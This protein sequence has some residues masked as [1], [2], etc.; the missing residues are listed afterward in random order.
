[1]KVNIWIIIQINLEIITSLHPEEYPDLS[2]LMQKTT[3]IS[4]LYAIMQHMQTYTTPVWPANNPRYF[5]FSIRNLV[6]W[7]KA[8]RYTGGVDTWQS[9]K[10]FL[11]H[12]G[13]IKTHPV[14]GEQE[15]QFL[16]SIWM[17][18]VKKGQ[19]SE[20]L[21]TV[22]FYT[23]AVLQQAEKIAREYREKHVNLTKITK[24]AIAIGWDQRT[25]DRLFRSSNHVVS[26]I[27]SQVKQCL[28]DAMDSMI[29]LHGYTT[30]AEMRSEALKQCQENLDINPTECLEL[31]DKLMA[32]KR[33]LIRDAGYA[34]H[35]IRKIDRQL[36][37]P[38][39]Y[40][41]YIITRLNIDEYSR[42]DDTLRVESHE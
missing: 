29:D 4:H 16:Q 32:Q 23:P 2:R 1:M 41:G 7:G 38:V 20:T 39:T 11:L 30:E 21:W 36:N 15:D 12:A 40:T 27:K 35:R 34:Y 28:K 18:A 31:I 8:N 14:I 42:C 9:H 37:I 3:V 17:S 10:I 33:A 25:A 5:L 6:R 22:P 26:R 24:D 19:R 13:L